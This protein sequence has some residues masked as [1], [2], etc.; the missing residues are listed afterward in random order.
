LLPAGLCNAV[1]ESSRTTTGLTMGE[2][3]E[4]MAKEN[5]IT[6]EAQDNS[7]CRVITVPPRP[8][9]VQESVR[10]FYFSGVRNLLRLSSRAVIAAASLPATS[11]SADPQE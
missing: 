3:A 5:G 9:T 10:T 7:R 6:R 1:A 11:N 2:S 8:E 4:K